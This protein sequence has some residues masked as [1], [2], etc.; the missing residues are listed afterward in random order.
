MEFYKRIL[1]I[2]IYLSVFTGYPVF[3]N[4]RISYDPVFFAP[5]LRPELWQA[6][7][8]FALIALLYNQ[9]TLR[10]SFFRQSLLLKY[11]LIIAPFFFFLL[12]AL[13][14]IP[15]LPGLP[16]FSPSLR[17]LAPICQQVLASL[18]TAAVVL[19][20]ASFSIPFRHLR[21]AIIF[22]PVINAT[23]LSSLPF[24]FLFDH[25]LFSRLTTE[26][27]V[28]LFA[29][30]HRFQGLCSNPNLASVTALFALALILLPSPDPRPISHNI[31]K[32]VL[33]HFYIFALTSII[34][35]SYTRISILL[36]CLLILFYL[37][38]Y[39]SLIRRTDLLWIATPFLTLLPYIFTKALAILSQ[40]P[41]GRF[42]IW[43]YYLSLLHEYPF[44][45][46]L[47]YSRHVPPPT[48]LSPKSI[49]WLGPHNLYIDSFFS[50]GPLGL[51]I[52]VTLL[53][54]LLLLAWDA[55]RY[56]G[57]LMPIFAMCCL[58]FDSLSTSSAFGF[59][60]QLAIM[61]ILSYC[62]ALTPSVQ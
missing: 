25:P 12:G 11:I 20:L 5:L 57:Y 49:S 26:H 47:L 35:L 54:G 59:V 46:S 32:I 1:F 2:P 48:Y 31:V 38:N 21:R 24:F 8:L 41:D 23:L 60:M 22:S 43:L 9:P 39:R 27:T 55:Y 4:T 44:G 53:L 18:Y 15:Y 45:A 6:T 29:Y 37:S 17:W 50:A 34:V 3:A 10:V 58:L 36:L 56:S 28:G 40:R 61:I 30:G 42:D 16:Q 33:K 14:F 19:S 51:L 7:S 52:V 62:Y 13:L